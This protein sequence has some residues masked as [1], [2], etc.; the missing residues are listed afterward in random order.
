MVRHS[1]LKDCQFALLKFHHRGLIYSSKF[2][3]AEFSIIIR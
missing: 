2:F 1:F 3:I